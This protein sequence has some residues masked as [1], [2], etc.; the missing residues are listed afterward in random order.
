MKA[1]PRKIIIFLSC[2]HQSSQRVAQNNG[3]GERHHV[4]MGEMSE[5][6]KPPLIRDNYYHSVVEPWKFLFSHS[7]VI[8]FSYTQ[9]K[10]IN[11]CEWIFLIPCKHTQN[12]MHWLKR[13]LNFT[14]QK[15]RVDESFYQ[16]GHGKDWLALVTADG[17][18][19]SQGPRGQ[20][21]LQG[22][23]NITS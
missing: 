9:I 2:I 4:P 5:N 7:F 22:S 21:K 3:K 10:Y 6:L 14:L 15:W 19:L 1:S 23:L 11:M 20:E 8:G 18:Q 12:K 13:Y 17:H 16:S